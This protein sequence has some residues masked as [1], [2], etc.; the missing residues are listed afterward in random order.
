MSCIQLGGIYSFNCLRDRK[1]ST[2]S[3]EYRCRKQYS[4]YASRMQLQGLFNTSGMTLNQACVGPPSSAPAISRAAAG[5]GFCTEFRRASGIPVYRLRED[6][7]AT[8][9]AL[10]GV[11][12]E[13]KLPQFNTGGPVSRRFACWSEPEETACAC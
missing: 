3:L 7:T 2:P 9:V 5:S 13:V 11:V 12:C 6:I 10:E 8:P 1:P 4:F